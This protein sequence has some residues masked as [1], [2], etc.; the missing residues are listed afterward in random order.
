M[1]CLGFLRRT[2]AHQHVISPCPKEAN[3]FQKWQEMSTLGPFSLFKK[4]WMFAAI[5][6]IDSV[7]FSFSSNV[8][9]WFPPRLGMPIKTG[10]SYP[11]I[12]VVAGNLNYLGFCH[13]LMAARRTRVSHWGFILREKEMAMEA[14]GNVKS[15]VSLGKG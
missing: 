8:T 9:T 1:R 4:P 15:F 14:R 5:C 10:L 3:K 7:S 13:E 6:T 12:S 11:E 2:N